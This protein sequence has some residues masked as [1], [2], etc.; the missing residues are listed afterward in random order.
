[1]LHATISEV[2]TL[3]ADSVLRAE[4]VTARLS[5]M[6]QLESELLGFVELLGWST[7]WLVVSVHLI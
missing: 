6:D 2:G 5:E 4:V 1:M 3:V 7:V